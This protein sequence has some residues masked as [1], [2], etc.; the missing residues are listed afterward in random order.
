M[1]PSL[2]PVSSFFHTHSCFGFFCCGLDC[3]GRAFSW[4]VILF[5][6]HTPNTPH[7]GGAQKRGRL[8]E[9]QRGAA[10][11]HARAL[12]PGDDEAPREGRQGK[13]AHARGKFDTRTVA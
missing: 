13:I 5:P 4:A 10:H 7:A 6:I 8:G 9:D 12:H 11:P 1:F 3:V 2:L